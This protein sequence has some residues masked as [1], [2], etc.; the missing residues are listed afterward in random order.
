ML[1]QQVFLIN[2]FLMITDAILVIVSGFIALYFT[3]HVGTI[4][5]VE[6][7]P[8]S[9]EQLF[10]IIILIFVNN[11]FLGLLGLYSDKR[12]YSFLF[13]IK[14]SLKIALL[15]YAILVTTSSLSDLYYHKSYLIYFSTSIFSSLTIFRIIA[16]V[17]IKLK[18]NLSHASRKTLI[19]G[20]EEKSTM[21]YN[22]LVNQVS[23]GHEFIGILTEFKSPSELV[24][25]KID[26]LKDIILNKTVD[27]VIFALSGNKDINL[28]PLIDICK[29]VGIQVKILPA[30]WSENKY[31]LSVECNQ[32]IPFICLQSNNIDANG[33]LYK[34]IVD[35]VGGFIGVIAFSML[36]PFLAILIKIDSPGPVL[37]TQ[38]RKGQHGRTFKLYKFRTM[39]SNA[40]ELKSK[41]L[42]QNEMKGFMFKMEDDPRITKIGKF[43]RKTSLDEFP[44]F[45]NVLKGE[46]SLVGTRP[47]TIEEVEKYKLEHLKRI[48]AKPGITGL[49]QISGRNKIKDF[50]EVVRLDCQYLD[51]WSLYNDFV[52]LLKTIHVGLVRKGAF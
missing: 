18:S 12:P 5:G 40:E 16:S 7:L 37:F 21:V 49:W 45:I 3:I 52:I 19:V 14:S 28:A 50:E 23:W 10:Y 48:S 26:D 42:D 17:H 9:T 32:G 35:I 8:T 36:Y 44:Q 1:Q 51:T 39:H 46:M 29:K 30:M 2:F 27:E 31:T 20:S 25:G 43:L 15:D 41:L 38:P 33:I 34:R 13:I 22:K 47:P 4:F 11:Y 6:P 24:I